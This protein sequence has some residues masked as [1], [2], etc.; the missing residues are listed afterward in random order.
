MTDLTSTDPA[1][2]FSL[3][4]V[5]VSDILALKT[6]SL[7]AACKPFGIK[8]FQRNNAKKGELIQKYREKGCIHTPDAAG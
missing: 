7:N 4:A 2:W 8:Q 3:S 5:S 1:Y 6:Q